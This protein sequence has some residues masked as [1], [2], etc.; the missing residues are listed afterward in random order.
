MLL[1]ITRLIG[2]AHRAGPSGIDRIELAYA[3]HFLVDG[4]G[5]R[6]AHA[7]VHL[8][9]W[10]FGLKRSCARRF[11]QKVAARWQGKA[12]GDARGRP[13]G[14]VDLYATLL[15]GAH[16]MAGW[17]LRL[18]LKRH[19][20]PP[21][22]LVVSHHELSSDDRLKKIRRILGAHVVAF[23]HDLIPVEYPQYV[24]AGVARRHLRMLQTIARQLDAVIVN[25]ETT[26]ASLRRMDTA[27][28]PR[29]YRSA[30]H[31]RISGTP[32]WPG[33]GGSLRGGVKY[34]TNWRRSPP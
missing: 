9:G 7:V 13:R 26:A 31:S 21:V 33:G 23:L 1:D 18:R 2:R 10:V 3:Q 27:L 25:S 5:G 28:R 4:M 34:S 14:V 19:R 17:E 20:V 11:V 24:E 8:K 29:L 32:N 16:W 22:Y 12:L 15:L 30:S 6:S